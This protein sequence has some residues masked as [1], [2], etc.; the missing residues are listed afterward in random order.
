VRG[1]AYNR[2]GTKI[3]ATTFSAGVKMIDDSTQVVSDVVIRD[4]LSMFVT[5]IAASPVA[6]FFTGA[7]MTVLNLELIHVYY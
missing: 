2:S 6:I 1:F 5:A 4:G 3:F 7:I